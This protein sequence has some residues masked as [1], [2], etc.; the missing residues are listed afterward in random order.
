MKYILLY[1]RLFQKSEI[2][3]RKYSIQKCKQERHKDTKTQTNKKEA[4]LSVSHGV[5]VFAPFQV[6]SPHFHREGK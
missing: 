6:E 4:S 3:K 1:L 2:S 5:S